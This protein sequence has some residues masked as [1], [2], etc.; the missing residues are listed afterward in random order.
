[1]GTK[2]GL[3]FFEIHFFMVMMLKV[4]NLYVKLRINQR[5]TTAHERE[6]M[7]HI[8]SVLKGI[9]YFVSINGIDREQIA[10]LLETVSTR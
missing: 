3:F 6:I 1:M 2:D 4:S 10:I 5:P 9:T 7:F 8:I